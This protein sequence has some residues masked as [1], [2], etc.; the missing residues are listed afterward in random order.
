MA[1]SAPP[2]EAEVEVGVQSMSSLWISS[3][4]TGKGPF[5]D[6]CPKIGLLGLMITGFDDSER[7]ARGSFSDTTAGVAERNLSNL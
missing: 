3:L 4:I 5:N 2:E 7:A 1:S 6:G